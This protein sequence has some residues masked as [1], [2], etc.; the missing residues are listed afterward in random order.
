M[1]LRFYSHE[2]DK[3]NGPLLGP[4]SGLRILRDRIVDEEK[5]LIAEMFVGAWVV[6]TGRYA[7]TYYQNISIWELE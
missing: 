5:Q 2:K 7:G 4:F 1:Y 3:F 6:R